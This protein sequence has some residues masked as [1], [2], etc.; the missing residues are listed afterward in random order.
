MDSFDQ[1]ILTLLQRDA[2]ISLKDLAEAVNLTTTPCWKRVK[3]LEDDGYIR[4]RVALLDPQRLN[5]GLSVFVQLKTQRHDS[6]WLEEFA[7]TVT[8]FEEVMEFYRMSGDWDYMLRVVVSDIAAYDRFYKR[9]ITSTEGLSNIT[10]SF[11]M[12][13]IKYTTA[14]PVS[15]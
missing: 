4:S 13:Q 8:A 11:A 6:V 2:S 5:L 12:E 1:H 10:S 7:R 15:R 9:L 14:F 3:R